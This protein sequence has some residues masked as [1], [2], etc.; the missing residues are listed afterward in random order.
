MRNFLKGPAVTGTNKTKDTEEPKNKTRG[1]ERTETNT[2][3]PKHGHHKTKIATTTRLIK[4][5]I[6]TRKEKIKKLKSD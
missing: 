1:R 4:P 5:L 6:Q 2:L 3:N